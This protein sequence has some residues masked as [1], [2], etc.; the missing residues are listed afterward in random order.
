MNKTFS[1]IKSCLNNPKSDYN[2]TYSEEFG[3]L[4]RILFD[5]NLYFKDG[6]TGFYGCPPQTGPTKYD[7]LP[8]ASV[9]TNSFQ[10]IVLE[11][12]TI[13]HEIGHHMCCHQNRK[14]V[15]RPHDDGIVFTKEIEAWRWAKKNW[16]SISKKSFPCDY[17][18]SCLQAY[19]NSKLINHN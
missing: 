11:K 4:I 14:N 15:Y 18:K 19:Y 2:H 7:H 17:V 3:L 10:S 16:N 13:L 12:A 6:P 8:V 9:S 1:W 5:K